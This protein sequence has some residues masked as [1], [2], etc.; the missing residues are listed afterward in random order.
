M[1]KSYQ[2]KIE[3]NNIFSKFSEV[4]SRISWYTNYLD[5]SNCFM[6]DTPGLTEGSASQVASKVLMG[7][8]N[9]N[10][11]TIECARDA[12]GAKTAVIPAR[13]HRER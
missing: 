13:A 1:E 5:L 11:E 8:L 7:S 6:S 9:P 12:T 3:I 10:L 4:W 2:N